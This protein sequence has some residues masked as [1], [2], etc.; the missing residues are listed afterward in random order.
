MVIHGIGDQPPLR[1]LGAFVQGL[2]RAAHLGREAGLPGRAR[3][4][5]VI[6]PLAGKARTL[7]RLPAGSVTQGEL[8]VLEYHWAEHALGGMSAAATFVWLLDVVVA[9]LDFRRQLPF[10]L[11]GARPGRAWP[12]VV[13]Q[14]LQVTGL[15]GAAA[16]ILVALLVVVARAGEAAAALRQAAARLPELPSLPVA[17]ALVLFL[18]LVA[19]VLVLAYDLLVAGLEARAVRRANADWGDGAWAGLYAPAAARWAAPGTA[20]LLLALLATFAVGSLLAPLLNGYL[21]V[22]LTVVTEPALA[23]ALAALAGILLGRSLLLS[24]V[25]DVAL[26]VTSDRLSSR[27]RTRRAILDEGEELVSA[28]LRAGYDGVYLAGHSLGSVVALDLLD[29]LARRSAAGDQ[30]PLEGVRGLLTFGSPLDK[31]AYFFRQRPGEDEAVRA[32]LLNVLHGVRRRPDMRDHGPHALA[33]LQQ[34]FEAVRW[35]QVHAP[36]DLLSDRLSH[37]RVDKRMVL[38]RYNP[39]TAHNAYW[40]DDRFFSGVIGWLRDGAEA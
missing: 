7:V 35:L 1:T 11:A 14:V 25:A 5:A 15:A 12:I 33:P 20:V 39:L 27:A 22:A 16:A 40:R 24:H 17:A 28:L 21:G 31:V 10:L 13:R 23:V 2:W 38:P 29:R 36:G 6:A 18:C 19:A 34:P 3:P 26:Y 30:L 8:D 4:T 32:Q 37:Y 9:G